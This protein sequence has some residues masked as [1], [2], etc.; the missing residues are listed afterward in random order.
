MNKIR[1][2]FLFFLILISG[3]ATTTKD[4][5]IQGLKNQI[6]ALEAQLQDKDREIEYL[7]ETL[8]EMERKKE[9]ILDKQQLDRIERRIHVKEKGTQP[10][11]KDI[12]IAL[13]NAGYNPGA[14]DG[15]MG[16]KTQEAIK[17][18]QRANN[19]TVDGKVGKETWNLLKNYLSKKEK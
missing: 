1:I 18:F 6:Q 17:A 11:V 5:Q 16:K 13:R 10:T 9:E 19:L 12:Q 2:I 8:R 14:I 7:K 4:Y 15:K 3:C